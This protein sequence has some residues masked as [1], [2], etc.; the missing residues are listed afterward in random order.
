MFNNPFMNNYNQ[1]QSL[2]RVNEQ[3]KQL[4]NIRNQMQQPIQTP[5]NLT[6]NFQLAPSNRE[7]MRY[8]NSM[9]DVQREVVVGDTAYFSKD[10]S[11]VWVKNP[12]GEIKTYELNEIVPKDDKDLKIEYLQAQIEQLRK[13]MSKDESHDNTYEPVTNAIESEESTDVSTVS[14]PGKKSKW[15]K[16]DIKW[17]GKQIQPRANETI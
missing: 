1:Q 12:K 10:M 5:T 11:V 3:I 4:E 13:E 15:S 9:E 17:Y 14:K 8:A 2:D 6:Q 16:K 7:T